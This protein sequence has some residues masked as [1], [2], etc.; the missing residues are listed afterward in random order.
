MANRLSQETSPYLLQHADNPVDWYPWGDEALERARRENKP[1]LLSIGYAAC[2]WCHVMAHE[3]FENPRIA[4]LMNDLFINIKVDR[5]ERP[6]LDAIYMQAVQTLTGRGGWPMTVFLMPDGV[7]FYGGTYFPPEDRHGM[8]GF[9]RVLLSI[10]DAYRT[11]REDVNSSGEELLRHLRQNEGLHGDDGEFDSSL[12]D[13]AYQQ[14]RQQFD[15]RNGGLGGAPKFPQPMTLEFLLRTYVRTGEREALALVELTLRKMAAGGIYD[16]LGGGFHRYSTDAVWLVPHFEKMLYDNAQLARVYLAAF[17]LTAEPLYRRVVE[18][19]LDYVL[20]EMTGPEGNFYSTQDADSDGV[21]GKFFVWT[22]DEVEAALGAEDAALLSGY[23]DVTGHGNWEGKNILHIPRSVEQVATV[24]GVTSERLQQAIARGRRL[25][26]ERREQRVKPGL[27][28]KTLTAWNGLMLRAFAEAGRALERDDYLQAAVRNAEFIRRS[29]TRDGRLLRSYRA[30]QSKLNGY[31]EDYSFLLNGLL[32]LYE[33][34]FDS[35]WFIWSLDLA[36]TMI[37]DFSDPTQ[38]GFFDTSAGHEALVLRPRDLF[39]NATPSGNSAA[40]EALLRLTA[41]TGD[42]EFEQHALALLRLLRPA[43]IRLPSGFGRMLC[44]ADF[45]LAA[46]KEVAIIG[47]L[48]ADDTRAL[49]RAVFRPYLP[50]TVVAGAAPNDRQAEAAVPLLQ[51]RVTES[52]RALAYV[53]ER[54]TCRAPVSEPAQ[55]TAELG[56]DRAPASGEGVTGGA[57]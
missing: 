13:A 11:R 12:L 6:D 19:T 55:L 52:T 4:A 7:P 21:E 39:D 49:R 27:D 46:R 2:H 36:R 17:Q 41:F 15:Q 31:L 30:G 57:R 14:L 45:A 1:I 40:A 43:M 38:A 20:R 33:A 50:A 24:A 16:Q 22:A 18:E 28:D 48:Q 35:R 56:L 54:F 23:F 8:P 26:F 5:E 51:G 9:P 25:L 37:D 32:S 53:C 34:T 3:S 47:R 42:E 10:A 44:A 29:L